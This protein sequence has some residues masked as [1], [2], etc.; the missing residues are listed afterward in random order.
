MSA[1]AMNIHRRSNEGWVTYT[2]RW[3]EQAH[4]YADNHKVLSWS[5]RSL[6]S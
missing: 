5:E 6:Y 1:Q 4:V 2:D 3:A